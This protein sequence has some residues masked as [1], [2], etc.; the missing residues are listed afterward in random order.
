[1]SVPNVPFKTPLGHD[2]L[3][4]R[5]HGLSQRHRTVLLLVDGRRP[6]AEVLSL[7]QKA[8]SSIAHFEDL[9]RLGMVELPIEAVAPEPV[10]TEPGALATLRSTAVEVDVTVPAASMVD[11]PPVDAEARP[12]DAEPRPG[13][14]EMTPDDAGTPRVDAEV[15]PSDA[16]VPSHVAE[17]PPRDAEV[18]PG[19]AVVL[20]GDAVVLPG[21]AETPPH[22]VAALLDAP[23][24]QPPRA[25]E[26]AAD[27]P[28]APPDMRPSGHRPVFDAVEEARPD[29]AEVD[30][31]LPKAPPSAPRSPEE[32]I[33]D[34][35]RELLLDALRENPPPF[36]S[37]LLARVAQAPSLDA[38]RDLVL[39]IER[40]VVQLRRG[41]GARR[42]L[43][44]AR[45]LL[46][47][48]NTVVTEDNPSRLDD[49]L[50]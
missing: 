40:H 18:P 23:E 46:G 22:D 44:R 36:G 37:R 24:A 39:E 1:M 45:D 4:R 43:E 49:D 33:A 10:M 29:A 38:L 5:A 42:H 19:D 20:P 34:E 48:G 50:Y 26:R 27:E 6:L 8:G 9:L 14:V 2:E 16:E 41:G 30:A 25:V 28:A 17:V 31:P 21:D 47:L 12:I 35:A 7:A 3:R 32:A 13:E 15:P 11:A